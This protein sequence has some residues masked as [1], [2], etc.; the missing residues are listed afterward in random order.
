MQQPISVGSSLRSR[1]R[2]IQVLGQG[3]FGR[4]YLV[5]DQNRF[6]EYCVLKE[7]VPAQA[8][9]E[10]LE[11]ARILFQQ[12]A[13]ILYDIHHPQ[14]PE[15][16]E[17]FEDGQRLF[18]VQQYIPGKTCWEVLQERQQQ[19][20]V[21]LEFEVKHLM[22]QLLTVLTYL[23]DRGIIH[24]DISPDNIIL[25]TSDQ[26]PVLIDFGAVKAIVTQINSRVGSQTIIGKPL[27]APIEQMQTGTVYPSSDLY[28]LAV[29]GIVLLSGKK[30]EALYDAQTQRWCWQ[31]G[32]IV[33][34]A[35]A[36]VLNQMLRDRPSDRYQSA[37]DV[38]AQL[39]PAVVSGG[40]LSPA[41]SV[42]ASYAATQAVAKPRP[43]PPNLAVPSSTLPEFSVWDH[44]VSQVGDVSFK[45]IKWLAR[46]FGRTTLILSKWMV[47]ITFRLIRF[48]FRLLPKWLILAVAIATGL[49]AYQQITGHKILPPITLPKSLHPS[50]PTNSK[51]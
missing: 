3:G 10:W 48:V 39:Q 17:F 6:R 2:I 28:S 19:H 18:F 32:V 27:Y 33:S 4:T 50:S 38:M 1:Y 5:E 24:R 25:R 8:S 20:L 41:P 44:F 11:K 40:K 34:P 37:K 35:F 13:K 36:A 49:W 9:R 47:R 45:T 51:E 21:F 23:H 31:Q 30:P 29:T 15:F 16:R 26:V 7:L 14:I 22:L 43:A 42:V 46:T 12:E